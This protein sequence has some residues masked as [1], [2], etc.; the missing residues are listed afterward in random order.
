MFIDISPPY[1]HYFADRLF[2]AIISIAALF[3]LFADVFA[4]DA[5]A[6][7]SLSPFFAFSP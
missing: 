1:A 7:F 5:F 4:A 2:F 3:L 6:A